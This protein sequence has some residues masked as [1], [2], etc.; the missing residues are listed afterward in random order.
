MFPSGE[1]TTH[2]HVRKKHIVVEHGGVDAPQVG[3]EARGTG[4]GLRGSHRSERR[5]VS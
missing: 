5:W 2:E 3:R 4:G 1:V